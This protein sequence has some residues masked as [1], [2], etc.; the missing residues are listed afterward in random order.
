[1]TRSRSTLMTY[2][3]LAAVGLGLVLVLVSWGLVASETDPRDQLAPLVA[4]GLGGL[5]AVVIGVVLVQAAT[6]RRDEEEHLRQLGALADGLA[7]L[8]R[9]IG[10]LR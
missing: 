10:L 6:A 4:A 1:M 9:E 7:E 5:A 8:R 2:A 3:G